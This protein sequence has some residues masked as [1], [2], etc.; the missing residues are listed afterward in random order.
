M[1][2]SKSKHALE[3]EA[4]V[5]I[6]WRAR[7]GAREDLVWDRDILTGAS[8]VK[9]ERHLILFGLKRTEEWCLSKLIS[10]VNNWI[11][12]QWSVTRAVHYVL[13]TESFRCG[14]LSRCW[15]N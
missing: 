15:E 12:L 3:W 1:R 7:P 10:T 14:I 13:L 9:S 5:D 6:I 8:L 2:M 4:F 11:D